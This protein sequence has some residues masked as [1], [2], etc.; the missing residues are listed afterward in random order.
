MA[1]VLR[2]EVN[3]APVKGGAVVIDGAQGGD[4]LD[5]EGGVA[6]GILELAVG[7]IAQH[8]AVDRLAFV[9]IAVGREVDVAPIEDTAHIAPAGEP[10]RNTRVAGGKGLKGFSELPLGGQN[11]HGFGAGLFGSDASDDGQLVAEIESWDQMVLVDGEL[12]VDEQV[13]CG[14]GLRFLRR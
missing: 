1:F 9:A 2:G 8:P 10:I 6:L 13:D 3:V 5:V 14:H 11:L 7:I 4:A 12:A